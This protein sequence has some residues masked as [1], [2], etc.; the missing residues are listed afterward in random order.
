MT[1]RDQQ[2]R[3]PQR[4]ARRGA[5]RRRASR[6]L[7]AAG[8]AGGGADGRRGR[9]VLSG[10]GVRGHGFA[11]RRRRRAA[12]SE[13]ERERREQRRRQRAQAEAMSACTTPGRTIWPPT[14]TRRASRRWRRARA[15]CCS[16]GV[17]AIGAAAAAAG[18]GR[19]AAG[20]R[21]LRLADQRWRSRCTLRLRSAAPAAPRGSA[22]WLK[23]LSDSPWVQRWMIVSPTSRRRPALSDS[24]AS[25][26]AAPVPRGS[27]GCRLGEGGRLS[28]RTAIVID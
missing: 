17:S 16:A 14:C 3:P 28:W 7:V 15:R 24:R 20:R 13:Q 5:P 1:P 8:G 4:V 11:G 26:R 2:R 21:E 23:P 22:L 18:A 9:R 25:R 10:S 19:A 27:S 6:R 12:G